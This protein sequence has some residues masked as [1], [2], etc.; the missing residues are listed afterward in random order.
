MIVNAGYRGKV[1]R[2]VP[3]FTYTGEYNQR[4]DGVVE[5]LTSGTITFLNPAVIDVFCVGGGGAGGNGRPATERAMGG[6]GGGYAAT[7]RKQR[8]SGSYAVTIGSGGIV[9][10]ISTQPSTDGG[11]T[12]FG[13]LLTAEGGKHGI[14]N[15]S[16]SGSV[17]TKGGD[18]GS[19]GGSATL[20]SQRGG[21]GGSDGNNG[22]A[23]LNGM[24]GGAGQ[25]STTREFGEADGKLY[26]GG[27]GGGRY[28][29]GQTPDVN[30]G[31]SGGGGDGAWQGSTEWFKTA[32][33]GVPNT[34]G[35]GGGAAMNSENVGG[36]AMGGGSGI[37]CFRA[38]K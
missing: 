14:C 10:S 32:T 11:T 15:N 4:D 5:L 34:G 35:G 1:G 18:G 6:G 31:G 33:P 38:A 30:P 37:C 17:A 21:S 26:S 12:S 23:G 3:K 36:K 28:R 16:N 22:E 19:G 27:G 25:G 9:P 20:Y 8:V 13:N 2:G 7:I 24:A 29:Y